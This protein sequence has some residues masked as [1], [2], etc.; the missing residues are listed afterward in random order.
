[1]D[2]TIQCLLIKSHYQK[3]ST[4][5]LLTLIKEFLNNG[6]TL[7]GIVMQALFKLMSNIVKALTIIPNQQVGK[8][9]AK[10]YTWKKNQM[11]SML[12]RTNYHLKIIFLKCFI[13]HQ[14]YF[15]NLGPD[16]LCAITI[17]VSSRFLFFIFIQNK[18]FTDMNLITNQG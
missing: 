13:G 14:S 11:Q 7:H 16:N 18:S 4:Q 12:C 6:I 2:D 1:M 10:K 8:L 5:Q 9:L 3:D 17:D 15:E